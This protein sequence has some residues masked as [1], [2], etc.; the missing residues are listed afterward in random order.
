MIANSPSGPPPGASTPGSSRTQT[1]P[2]YRPTSA[3]VTA[4]LK[5]AD[6]VVDEGVGGGRRKHPVLVGALTLSYTLLRYGY[7]PR[8]ADW[9]T[10]ADL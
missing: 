9:L 2:A 10:V 1:G 3:A 7:R 4:R 5:R 8:S 6:V